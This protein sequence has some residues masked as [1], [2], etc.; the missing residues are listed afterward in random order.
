MKSLHNQW[1]SSC[2][3][4][5]RAVYTLVISS[6]I[7]EEQKSLSHRHKPARGLVLLAECTKRVAVV[8]GVGV[9][10]KHSAAL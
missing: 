4:Y 1:F 9:I 7:H 3:I 8:G 6:D 10:E 5:I 2:F